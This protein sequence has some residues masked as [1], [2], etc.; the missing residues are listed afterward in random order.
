MHTTDF[1][2]H[3]EI[4]QVCNLVT[5]SPASGQC[6]TVSEAGFDVVL[7][8]SSLGSQTRQACGSIP[9]PPPSLYLTSLIVKDYWPRQTSGSYALSTQ[10]WRSSGS[11]PLG[12]LA[13][14]LF[15]HLSHF[16]KSPG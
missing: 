7:V 4:P 15:A 16:S 14:F 8:M 13:G 10:D 2:H 9:H 6:T 11:L 3:S 5:P 1:T 12:L